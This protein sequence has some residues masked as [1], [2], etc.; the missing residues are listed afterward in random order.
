MNKLIYILLFFLIELNLDAQSYIPLQDL[1]AFKPTKENWKITGDLFGDNTNGG[2]LKTMPGQG[3]LVCERIEGKSGM[4]YDLFTVD[5]HGD[6]DLD[7]D[8]VMAKG[9][10]S[11]IYLQSRYEVQ[12]FDSWGKS[13]PKYNDCGGIYERWNDAKP[14]GQQGYEGTAP[15]IN[16]AKA[17]GLWQN[18][19]ISFQAPRFDA[20]GKK[21]SNAK[22]ISIILNGVLIHEN[23]DVSGPTRGPVMNN[24]VAM[25]PLRF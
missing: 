16:V 12:L 9:S 18:I 5:S 8:F 13:H 4:D 21:I 14:E 23:V 19:K 25:A 10:N 7:L 11:G 1:T 24:E 2:P 22:F 6:L 17:P 15:R 20:S 3:V